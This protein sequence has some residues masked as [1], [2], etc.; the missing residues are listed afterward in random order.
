MEI[1]YLSKETA[2]RIAKHYGV[3][4]ESV[5]SVLYSSYAKNTVRVFS[6]DTEECLKG[7]C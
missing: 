7:C 1:V 4:Q 6:L 2:P 5:A 3:S